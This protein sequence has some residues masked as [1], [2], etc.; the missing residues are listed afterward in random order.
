MPGLIAELLFN[1]EFHS[2]IN[3]A[4]CAH[5]QAVGDRFVPS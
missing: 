4:V 1:L 2:L 3:D 5:A